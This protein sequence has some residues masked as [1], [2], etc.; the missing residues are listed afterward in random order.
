MTGVLII[1]AQVDLAGQS[2]DSIFFLT[3]FV[4]DSLFHP[5]PAS[6]VININSG[7]GDV[8]NNL[9]IFQLPV[10]ILDTLYFRNIAYR[11]TL[12]PAASFSK[13]KYIRIREK[14]HPIQEARVF[15]WGST[16][17][18]FKEAIIHMPNAQSLGESLGLP[19]QDPDYIPYNL[20]EQKIKS[21]GFLINSPVSFLYHNLSRKERSAR[22]LFRIKRNRKKQEAYEEI[23][24]RSNIASITGISGTELDRFLYFLNERIQCDYRCTELEVYTEIHSLWELYQKQQLP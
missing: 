12:V 21:V 2:G 1:A 5:V 6:H 13:K 14:Y 20:D 19:R 15:E 17:Q 11:D 4:Y 24:S 9:G 8:T 7:A 18:D 16:Y 10:T 22:K 23:L 3:G